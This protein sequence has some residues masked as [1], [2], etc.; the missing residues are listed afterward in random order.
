MKKKKNRSG[1]YTPILTQP[2]TAADEEEFG[3]NNKRKGMEDIRD[4]ATTE[5]NIKKIPKQQS[6]NAIQYEWKWI[7][8]EM[9]G[10]DDTIHQHER[11]EK[12]SYETSWGTIHDK[13]R[14]HFGTMKKDKKSIYSSKFDSVK[15]AKGARTIYHGTLKIMIDATAALLD[16]AEKHGKEVNYSLERILWRHGMSS[17]ADVSPEYQSELSIELIKGCSEKVR[18]NIDQLKTIRLSLSRHYAEIL[19]KIDRISNLIDNGVYTGD[20]SIRR[21]LFELMEIQKAIR[22]SDEDDLKFLTNKKIQETNKS[23]ENPLDRADLL[24]ELVD[25]RNNKIEMKIMMKASETIGV[26]LI[27]WEMLGQATLRA[28][29]E[30]SFLRDKHI[31]KMWN[32]GQELNLGATFRQLLRNGIQY[33]Y[34]IALDYTEVKTTYQQFESNIEDEGDDD[35]TQDTRKRKLMKTQERKKKS[36]MELT[37]KIGDKQKEKQKDKAKKAT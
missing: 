23:L 26:K 6:G 13:T 15:T 21:R 28:E 10:N 27:E 9:N 8:S 29:A 11:N 17:P 16:V 37:L 36:Q 4:K 35:E 7:E 34:K 31:W 19:A 30:Y 5:K 18:H 24:L 20:H 33:I 3:R 32:N 14:M 2:W 25:K 22:S 12:E 1:K